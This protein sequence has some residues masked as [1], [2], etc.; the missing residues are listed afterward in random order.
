MNNVEQKI[1]QKVK[2][3]NLFDQTTQGTLI[4]FSDDHTVVVLKATGNGKGD[5]E[6]CKFM[7]AAFIKSIEVLS[8]VPKKSQHN[9][10]VWVKPPSISIAEIK[11]E[12]RSALSEQSKPKNQT[13]S[14]VSPIARK[15]FQK[16]VLKFGS[17]NVRWEGS[18]NIIL[19][20]EIKLSKP[21]TLGKSGNITKI[22]SNSNALPK[23]E[24]ILKEFWLE[25]N[26]SKKGG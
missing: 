14:K 2:I 26:D 22:T 20:D 17:K 8:P 19:F 1:N 5:K 7:N 10:N 24:A 23:V 3:I 4:A 13:N 25:T 11:N 15:I 9:S 21:Y 6:N 16:F 18:A 12:L